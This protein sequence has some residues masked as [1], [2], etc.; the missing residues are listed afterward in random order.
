MK[1]IVYIINNAGFFVSH[2]LP[3]AEEAIKNNFKVYLITGLPGS[4]IIDNDAKSKLSKYEI[5]HY[6]VPFS[7][8]GLNP[9][10]ETLHLIRIIRILR[11]I[12]PDIIHAASPKGVFLS[13]L[14]NLF[15][16]SRLQILSISGMGFL[17]SSNSKSLFM[18]IIRLVFKSLIVTAINIRKTKIIVQNH[19]DY[20]DWE[21]IIFLN[22]S[23]I[24]LIPGSGVD[25][26]IYKDIKYDLDSNIILF[27][28][29]LLIEKGIINFVEASKIISNRGYKWRFVLVGTADYDSPG[30]VSMTDLKKWINLGLVEWMG[31][32]DDMASVYAASSIV[33]LPTY[34][35]G[36]PKSLLEASASGI[37]VITTNAVGS[38]EAIVEN[39]TGLLVPVDDSRKL[40]DSIQ[41][42][43]DNPDLRVKFGENGKKHAEEKFSIRKVKKSFLDLYLDT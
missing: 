12:K 4:A 33:C 40:A 11:I 31:H 28:S 13:S 1:K 2:R 26:K 17:Y 16:G 3:L 38:K 22:H 15:I 42:L 29:R 34:R 32:Q 30:S 14:A 23:S 8:Q 37:P 36:L 27:P 7:A 19:D 41:L 43:I 35:E 20:T 18:K 21:K 9:I 25:T 39:H 6:T 24:D 10:K 5:E